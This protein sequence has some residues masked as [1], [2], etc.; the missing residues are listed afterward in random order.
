LPRRRRPRNRSTWSERNCCGS[1]CLEALNAGSR[2]GP[3]RWCP[4][5]TCE[6]VPVL[7]IYWY[8]DFDHTST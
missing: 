5:R 7:G 4:L 6:P 3:C 1:C 8:D 2:L